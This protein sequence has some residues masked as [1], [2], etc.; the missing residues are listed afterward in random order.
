MNWE[1]KHLQIILHFPSCN[2]EDQFPE[3]KI[4]PLAGLDSSRPVTLNG[5]YDFQEYFKDWKN[6]SSDISM[7]VNLVKE[8]AV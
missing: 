5:R 6:Q 7:R 3:V 4:Y 8:K 2:I 1:G